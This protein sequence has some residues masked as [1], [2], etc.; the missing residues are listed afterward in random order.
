[1]NIANGNE[2][3]WKTLGLFGESLQIKDP[4]FDDRRY[5]SP[6]YGFRKSNVND[7]RHEKCCGEKFPEPSKIPPIKDKLHQYTYKHINI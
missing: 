7:V 3:Y 2:E 4:L 6:A 5:G 1:M